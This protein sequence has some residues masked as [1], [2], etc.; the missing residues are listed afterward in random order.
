MSLRSNTTAPPCVRRTGRSTSNG[1]D[2]LEIGSRLSELG[3]TGRQWTISSE[4]LRCEAISNKRGI[5]NVERDRD[6]AGSW[7]IRSALEFFHGA[8]A[9]PKEEPDQGARW[10]ARSHADANGKWAPF[11][12]ASNVRGIACEDILLQRDAAAL[13]HQALPLWAMEGSTEAHMRMVALDS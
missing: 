7:R 3:D 5:A 9:W 4:A 1:Q 13:E 12:R 6:G 11:S 8:A 2:L 10:W